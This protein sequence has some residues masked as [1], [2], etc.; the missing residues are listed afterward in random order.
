MRRRELV[1]A[2]VAGV[3]AW[4]HVNSAEQSMSPVIGFLH[5]ASP[6]PLKDRLNAF[7]AGL[8]EGGYLEGQ[9]VA[10][11]YRWAEG[12]Y[13]RF[14]HLRGNSLPDRSAFWFQERQLQQ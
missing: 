6:S 4:P 13:D 11:E 3:A 7:R 8:K 9:N 1:V 2:L 14:P 5:A 12:D 10:I